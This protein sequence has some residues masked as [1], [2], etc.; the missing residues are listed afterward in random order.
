VLGGLGGYLRGNGG[1][2]EG[3][4]TVAVRATGVQPGARGELT[5]AD[6]DY[7]A[8]VRVSGLKPQRGRVYEVWLRPEGSQAVKPSSLFAVKSDG[9]GSAAIP[10]GGLDDVA[11]VMVSSE[12]EGGS[13][14]P[15]TDPVLRGTL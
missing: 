12:P 2:D 14:T 9:T 10:A 4:T 8:I 1:G 11:E 3:T 6:A 5:R 7:P 15:T 13:M